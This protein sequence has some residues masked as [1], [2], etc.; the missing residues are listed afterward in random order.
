MVLHG[1]PIRTYALALIAIVT[2]ACGSGSTRAF[3]ASPAANPD[4]RIE[5]LASLFDYEREPSSDDGWY[6]V[7]DPFAGSLVRKRIEPVVSSSGTLYLR[8]VFRND[9]W[10]YHDQIVVRIGDR[11]IES[12]QIPASDRRNTRRV[13]QE[14]TSETREARRTTQKR[15]VSEMILFTNGSDNGI[16]AAIAANSSQA[17]ELKFVGRELSHTQPI[18]DDDKKRIAAGVELARLLREKRAATP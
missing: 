12:S 11:E 4:T 10:I 3:N 18:S 1:F 8:S 13:T 16:L 7:K 5:Q 15:Y 6:R 17:I 14:A 9:D 2:P